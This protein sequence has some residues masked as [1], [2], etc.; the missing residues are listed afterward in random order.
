[1]S[2]QWPNDT[3]IRNAAV[4]AGLIS[5]SL[6]PAAAQ[7]TMEPLVREYP[8]EISYRATLA[9][10]YLKQGRKAEALGAF[11]ESVNITATAPARPSTLAVHALVLNA[12]NMS[13]LARIEADQVPAGALIP[14]ERTLL[15]PL[16]KNPSHP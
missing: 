7:A 15:N 13:T 5:G 8:K 9:L 4:Y 10:A 2:K 6:S 3:G 16:L 12:N 14:E 11:G 1:M